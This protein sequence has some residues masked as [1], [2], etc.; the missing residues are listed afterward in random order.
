MYWDVLPPE[1]GSQGQNAD[2]KYE[3]KPERGVWV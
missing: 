2:D 3:H 1:A